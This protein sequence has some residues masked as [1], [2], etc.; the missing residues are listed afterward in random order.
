[1]GRVETEIE[2]E[3]HSQ[4]QR[5]WSSS[6]LLEELIPKAVFELTN[7]HAGLDGFRRLLGGRWTSIEV[8]HYGLS[9]GTRGPT[10]RTYLRVAV[11]K[12]ILHRGYHSSYSRKC[13]SV[14]FYLRQGLHLGDRIWGRLV[15]QRAGRLLACHRCDRAKN[16]QRR[17]HQ[18]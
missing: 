11:F 2:L 13:G 9:N 16:Q 8:T 6:R 4:S 5:Q 12:T 14:G 17:T 10:S 18:A 15:P 7:D 3:R 1:M